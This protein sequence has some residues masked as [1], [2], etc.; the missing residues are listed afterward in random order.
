[1]EAPVRRSI[2]E[3][4]AHQAAD[5]VD[6]A[7][8]LRFVTRFRKRTL[9]D[10][11]GARFAERLA[12]I[13]TQPPDIFSSPRSERKS[14]RRRLAVRH[15]QSDPVSAESAT[16]ALGVEGATILFLAGPTASGK[17]ALALAVAEAAG[18]EIVNADSMQVYADLEVISARPGAEELA[19][20]PHH[21]YGHVDAAE[22][23]SVGRWS[24][25]AVPL[26]KDI[27]ARGR[28]AVVVGGTGLYFKALTDGLAEVPDPGPEAEEFARRLLNAK[29]V[30]GLRAMAEQLDPRGAAQVAPTDRQRLLRLVAVARGVGKPLSEL[31]ANTTP[32]IERSAWRG[33]VLEPDRAHLYRRIEAR[34]HR[35]IEDGGAEEAARLVARG[36]P[37]DVPAMKALGV[38]V[39]AALHA[40]AIDRDAAF[41]ALAGD[42]RRYAKRQLTWFR[43]QTADWARI[44][45]VSPEGALAAW[46]GQRRG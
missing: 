45:T 46:R 3:A 10:Y 32:P 13:V 5:Q 43:H 2:R 8:E 36:L 31:R 23:Y 7:M 18:A 35:M 1:L 30:E 44:A 14:L 28:S 24:A 19:L 40:G 11:F 38:S 29:G 27:L 37:A 42:T 26:L 9:A 25:E 34:A 33:L 22:H 39:L 41:E 6:V 12:R 21:L 20:A 4:R 17:S 15:E 16:S